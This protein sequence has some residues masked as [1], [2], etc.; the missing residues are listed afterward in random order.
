MKKIIEKDLFGIIAMAILLI[1]QIAH[2]LFSCCY[3]FFKKNKVTDYRHKADVILSDEVLEINRAIEAGIHFKPQ[4]YICP[5]CRDS[6]SNSKLLDAH[7]LGHKSQK[8]WEPKRYGAW[9]LENNTRYN[10]CS[11][12]KGY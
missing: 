10:Y 11:N 7:I 5:E 4:P 3:L 9:E 2:T 6:F 8:D 12:L 1:P